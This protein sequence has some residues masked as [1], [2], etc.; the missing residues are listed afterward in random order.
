MITTEQYKRMLAAYVGVTDD[1]ASAFVD[2]MLR[3]I[4][5]RLRQGEE[6][7]L[8]GIGT[9]R[10]VEALQGELRR[11]AF[12]CDP[13]MRDAVNAP[14]A[15]FEPI[16]V[17]RVKASAETSQPASDNEG[18]AS[19]EA[20]ASSDAEN[21]S[22]SEV[23]PEASAGAPSEVF[24]DEAESTERT[25]EVSS[26]N[27]SSDAADGSLSETE[28]AAQDGDTESASQPAGKRKGKLTPWGVANICLAILIVCCLVYI[29]GAH[30]YRHTAAD[31]SPLAEQVDNGGALT[32]EGTS[33]AEEASTMEEASTKEGISTTEEIS[34][35]DGALAKDETSTE[36]GTSTKEAASADTTA[37]PRPTPD[38]L[39]H[40][41]GKPRTVVLQPGQRL[42]LVSLRV[43]GD[44]AFWCYIYDVNAFQLTDPNNV[45]VGTTLYLPDPTYYQ[46]D[47]DDPASLRRAKQR[48]A[49][50]LNP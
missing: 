21:D 24:S 50:L 34:V 48:A 22:S 15:C 5:Q 45:P 28:Q 33:T 30:P 2:A 8:G 44:K 42:T 25:E 4:V 32:K 10:V 16:V 7:E 39:L 9:F 29:F 12:V 6:V 11:V 38:M 3:V 40:E 18:E 49:R 13:K 1:E 43:Y 26:S 14:F 17:G 35:S 31:L 19:V 41:G 20:E 36:T 27:L 47:A 46:I 23:E 37:L